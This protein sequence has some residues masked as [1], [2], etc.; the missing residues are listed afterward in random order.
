MSCS[1]THNVY[2]LHNSSRRHWR[3]GLTR[4][5]VTLPQGNQ[6]PLVVKD[7]VGRPLSELG[8]NKTVECDTFPFSG[9]TLLVGRQEGHQAS[10]KLYVGDDLTGALYVL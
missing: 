5:L 7:M 6:E 9:L 1:R 8:V 4:G 10:I 3:Q 2:V